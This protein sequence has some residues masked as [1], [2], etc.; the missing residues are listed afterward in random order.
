MS[1][2]P[3]CSRPLGDH[4]V[5]AHHLI[6]RTFKGRETIDLHRICHQKIHT[7]FSERELLRH[8]HTVE[9]LL[10]HEQIKVFVNWVKNKP[11]DFYVKNDDSADRKKKR[12]R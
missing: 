5:E 2:C 9:R 6:P 11:L 1:I 7:T 3:L 8:Y 10:E 4:L 12:K